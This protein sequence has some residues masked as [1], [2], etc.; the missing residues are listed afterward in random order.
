MPRYATILC[1]T[2]LIFAFPVL[3]CGAGF[4]QAAA[5]FARDARV[6]VGP[7][8][9]VVADFN[10]DG[11][12]DI[13]TANAS[14][15]VA[16]LL[17]NGDGTFANGV[18]ILVPGTPSSLVTADF[19]GDGKPD[20]AVSAPDSTVITILLG[21]S[22]GTFRSG[23]VSVGIQPAQIAV[24]DFNGD[25]RPDIVAIN[26]TYSLASTIYVLSGRGDGTFLTA[27][28]S[29][30]G[31]AIVPRNI[32]V[33]DFDGDGK[34]DLAV[35]GYNALYVTLFYGKGDGTFGSPVRTDTS[36]TMPLVGLAAGD[37]NG[38][39]RPDLVS[40]PITYNDAG[41]F[42]YSGSRAFRS[43]VQYGLH[44]TSTAFAL[45]DMDGD[46]KQ[47]M[48]AAENGGSAGLYYV[49]IL[50]GNGD[51]TFQNEI[52]ASLNAAPN[53]V[54]IA[55]VN[56]DGKPDVIAAERNANRVGVLLGNGDGTLQAENDY[57]VG[58]NPFAI[59]GVPGAQSIAIGDFNRDG[60]LDFVVPT[61][62]GVL[63]VPGNGDGTFGVPVP[64]AIDGGAVYVAVGD[65]NGDGKPDIATSN[66]VGS[67]GFQHRQRS[68]RQRGRQFPVSCVP[69]PHYAERSRPGCDCRL[70]RGREAERTG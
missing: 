26:T 23:T 39:G 12:P 57:A 29:S 6:G 33:A 50:R 21:N 7:Q 36:R 5:I 62:T 51:G 67:D 16:I 65:V 2:L 18:N 63:V 69:H 40:G 44:N 3:N 64:L 19:N 25:G 11:K 22:D 49:G 42:T 28:V 4:A 10:G 46:G 43:V 31:D 15:S 13:A 30:T 60:K 54:K 52:A 66:N 45:T 70:E 17:N 53:D 68:D 37:V 35:T 34:S 56:G 48:I 41:V 20:L 9:L 58:I 59:P 8:A 47:D 38:D 1:H 32:V 55:D 24:G 14:G 27:R 61:A